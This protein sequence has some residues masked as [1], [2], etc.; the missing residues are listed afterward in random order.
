MAEL[1]LT[2]A[3][4]A[5][6]GIPLLDAVDL[7]IERGE[8]IGL[9]GRNGAGKSTLL[10]I[11]SGALLPDTGTVSRRQGL[12]IAE[13]PQEVP[14]TLE[15]TVATQLARALDGR[16]LAPLEVETRVAQTLSRLS[17]EGEA[18]VA[19]LSAGIKR[20]VLMA[21]A[22]IVEPDLL[23]LD[24]PT[25]HLDIDAILDLQDMLQQRRGALIFVTHDREFLRR[26]ATRILDL[27]R[28]ALRSYP[29]DYATYLERREALLEAEG[30]EQALFDKKLAAEEV[31]VRRGIRARR[32]R[33]EGRVR[34][35]EAMRETRRARRDVAGTVR[36]RLQEAERGGRIVLRTE[37]L[38]HAFEG[39]PVVEQ[40]TTT[41]VR[42]DRIGIIGPNGCGKTTLLRLLLGELPPRE[43]SV[44]HGTRLEV[45]RFDQLHAV[46]DD[47]KSVRENVCDAGDTV[48]IDGR[49]RNIVG[50][51][52]DFLFTREQI[53][54]STQQLSGGERNRLQL[55]RLLA[56]PCNLLV[57]DEPTNDLDVETLEMLE[58][59]L[60][61]FSGTLLVVSHDRAFINNVVTSTLVFEGDGRVREYVGGF[62]DWVRQ[63]PVAAPVPAA[64]KKQPRPRP[65]PQ[66]PR[67]LTFKERRE[68]EGLPAQIE[69]LEAE[70][71][72]LGA[73]MA[74]ADFYKRPGNEITADTQRLETV[75]ADLIGLYARWE[76]LETIASTEP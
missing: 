3:S 15:G 73:A 59:W 54:G 71:G 10:R 74:G 16:A 51:L 60:A 40:L 7:Q 65:A 9:V 75:E 13:L 46:L 24:E 76:A 48:T 72:A 36:A 20:R 17:L 6:D 14:R 37:G 63:R 66:R 67:R 11:L 50:Y 2:N 19:D 41:I 1:G 70:K 5:L 33:N 26:L 56:R 43:G 39:R 18:L 53:R 8:R 69:A 31:W 25:N 47:S 27:D 61:G 49:P 35:L 22:L 4:Y 23:L 42:G 29:C 28:G 32:T 45:A 44:H 30:R 12:S 58:A 34:A 57:L 62:D 55:A 21:R 68:L 64:P 38:C 52:E